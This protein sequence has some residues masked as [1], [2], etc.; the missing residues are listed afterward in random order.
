MTQENNNGNSGNN[1]SS[2]HPNHGQG[3]TVQYPPPL[4][5]IST[6]VEG[7]K[8]YDHGAE[9]SNQRG[10]DVDYHRNNCELEG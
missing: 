8:S 1:Q 7:K 6:I 4:N 5:D 3:L 2:S 10:E 9:N